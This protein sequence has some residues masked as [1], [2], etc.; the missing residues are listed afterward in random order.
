MANNYEALVQAILDQRR[1]NREM[2]ALQN[3][4]YE[5]RNI[6]INSTN[7]AREIQQAINAASFNININPVV[8]GNQARNIGQQYGQDLSRGINTA[9]NSQIRNGGVNLLENILGTANGINRNAVNRII[10]GITQDIGTANVQIRNMRTQFENVKDAANGL[11]NLRISGI[12]DLG[13]AVTNLT[14]IDNETG[15][16][17]SS[18]TTVTQN[19]DR[20]AE[21][22]RRANQTYH[23]L[24][25]TAQRMGQIATKINGLDGVED[26]NQIAALSTQLNTLRERFNSVFSEARSQGMLSER[27][28]NN[29]NNVIVDG[30]NRINTL[31]GALR[32]TANASNFDR[33]L[34]TAKQIGSMEIKIAGLD[35]NK[36]ANQISVLTNQL[37]ELRST[38]NSLM[39]SVGGNLSTSQTEELNRILTESA[40]KVELVKAK[41]LDA[42]KKATSLQVITFDNEMTGW[43]DKNT[44]A[45][46]SF[47]AS[48]D[49]LR[50]KLQALSTS[51]D[52]T[53]S[54]LK[55]LKDEF[56]SIKQQAIAAGEVGQT[57]G[58]RFRKAFSS[59]A[60]YISVATVIGAATDS[61]RKMY[62]A[63]SEIDAAMINLMKVTD[64]SSSRYQQ[65]LQSS[66]ESAREL[67]RSISGLVE[68]TAT[69]AKLGYSLDESEQLAKISS[70][71]ANVAEVSDA[72]AVSDMVT[73]MKAFNIEAKNAISI[74]DPLNELGN[75]FATSAADLGEGLTKSASAMNAA[76]TDMYK[77]LALLTGGAEI[78]QNAGEFGSF[79]KVASMRIRGMKGELEEL[80]EEVDDNI[81]S[82]SKV[83]TQILNLTHGKVNIFNDIGE[84]RDY[85]D[86]MQDIANVMKELTSTEQASLSEI[87]FGKMRGNQGAALIQAFQSGQIQKAYQT[88]INSAGSAYME[89]QKYMEGLEAKVAQL[90]A[91][92]QGLS[93]A[94]L[95]SDFLKGLVDSGT[96]ALSVLT[97]IIEKAGTLPTILTVA[98]AAFSLKNVGRNKMSFLFE[99]TDCKY[100]SI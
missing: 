71:Y 7:L 95:N 84:F 38:Y 100:G 49:E 85:Y 4:Q 52:L 2:E 40:N 63:V 56:K 26:A 89:Q 47:G 62:D 55:D 67:G 72:T 86:I 31:Q 42:S 12:D 14:R 37:T 96:T 33:L 81:E 13:N 24:Y 60:N 25:T 51:G 64:E 88:A 66:A 76:G 39:S 45:S 3:G 94:F 32:D 5:L 58:S 93:Q 35:G 59:I 11:R 73:A 61:L 44:R 97:K 50:A 22:A 68:Q 75:K 65:F 98:T 16:V 19:F 57:F 53:E 92:F 54:A 91:A 46:K 43:L 30:I 21:A 28:M 34:A 78:T 80:G 82:I 70:I 27:Q 41:I 10:N 20:S 8:N 74:I 99:Y 90:Q 77:T 69:W 29:L 9:I 83:Q 87:L 36:N 23:E 15:N 6:H 1:F 18:L 48:I 79:L 17:V